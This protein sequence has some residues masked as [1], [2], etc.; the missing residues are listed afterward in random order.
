MPSAS[1]FKAVVA[2]FV[3]VLITRVRVGRGQFAHRRAVFAFRDF[4]IVE[5]DIG[6]RVVGRALRLDDTAFGVV[7][8]FVAA[9]S[10]YS[11]L[12]L[13]LCPSS[14]AVRV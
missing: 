11:A 3:G 9:L 10:V 5:A 7:A 6:R 14:S 4:V 1:H 8:F 13:I 2:Y 12:T